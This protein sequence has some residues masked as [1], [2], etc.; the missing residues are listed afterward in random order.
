MTSINLTLQHQDTRFY[1]AVLVSDFHYTAK[2]ALSRNSLETMFSRTVNES[3]SYNG[4]S[5]RRK[6]LWSALYFEYAYPRCSSWTSSRFVWNIVSLIAG[7]KLGTLL[8]C[9]QFSSRCKYFLKKGDFMFTTRVKLWWRREGVDATAAT[10]TRPH[11]NDDDDDSNR[12]KKNI[13]IVYF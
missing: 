7:Y 13:S 2:P 4:L 1:L 10:N 6:I 8:F 9:V 12:K 11:K 3:R 5:L